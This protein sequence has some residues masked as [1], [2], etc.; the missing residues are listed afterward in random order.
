MENIGYD[1]YI[2][3]VKILCIENFIIMAIYF[4]SSSR[5]I[6][7]IFSLIVLY[8]KPKCKNQSSVSAMLKK[9]VLS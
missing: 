1:V 6:K 2:A 9:H 3:A 8:V 7:E 4:S 5:Q